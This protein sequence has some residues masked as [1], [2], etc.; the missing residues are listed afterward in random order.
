MN[1]L[2][3]GIRH[4]RNLPYVTEIRLVHGSAWMAM[5]KKFGWIALVVGT[6]FLFAQRAYAHCDTLNG[7]VVAAART[8]LEKGDVTPVLR[9]V[10]PQFEEEIHAAFDRARAVR[11]KDA[12]ARALADQWFFET[13]VRIHR[14]GE[15]EPFTGLKDEPAEPVFE[16]ADTAIA[17]DSIEKLKPV[18]TADVVTGL[19]TRFQHLLET[20]KHADE[21]VEAGRRYVAAYVDFVHY[22]EMLHSRSGGQHDVRH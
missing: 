15:G 13:L 9:W 22:V 8:A 3:M 18:V 4:I 7:P 14:E 6:V 17:Q 12:D 20:K 21:S 1:E 19:R 11:V 16:A 10:Q 5:I 2:G